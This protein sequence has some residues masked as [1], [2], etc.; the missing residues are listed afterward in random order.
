MGNGEQSGS[1]GRSDWPIRLATSV[2]CAIGAALGLLLKS[3]GLDLGGFWQGAIAFGVL[4]G[5][6]G[7]LGRLVGSLLFRRPPDR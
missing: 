6:G 7:V 4:I 1:G 3:Q 5:V 2:G